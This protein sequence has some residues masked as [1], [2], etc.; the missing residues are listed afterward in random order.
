MRSVTGPYLKSE[1]ATYLDFFCES[2]E[3][4]KKG[5][6][7][8]IPEVQRLDLELSHHGGILLNAAYVRTA[9]LVKK[10][11]LVA[12]RVAL[13]L[14][15]AQC[16]DHRRQH[17]AYPESLPEAFDPLTGKSFLFSRGDG[18]LSIASPGNEKVLWVLPE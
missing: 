18:E 3:A 1:A 4:L 9:N 13:A 11:A 17:G 15:A 5:Y 14:L 8:A 7:H 6:P 16:L 2:S 10:E 12:S